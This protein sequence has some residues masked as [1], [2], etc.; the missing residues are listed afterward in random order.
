MG[1]LGFGGPVE[2][3]QRRFTNRRK[4]AESQTTIP[5]GV[6][7]RDLPQWHKHG[8]I[9]AGERDGLTTEERKAKMLRQEKEILRRAPAVLAREEIGDR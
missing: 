4:D 2:A 5:T 9:N 1:L 8:E 3:W 7:P 6:P